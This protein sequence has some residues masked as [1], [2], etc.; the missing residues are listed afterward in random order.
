MFAVIGFTALI[1]AVS[2]L[3]ALLDPSSDR[4]RLA[5]ARRQLKRSGVRFEKGSVDEHR[6]LTILLEG[7][8]P[9]QVA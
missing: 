3:S 4:A 5:E 7:G 1:A 6:A 2:A 9:D 8:S